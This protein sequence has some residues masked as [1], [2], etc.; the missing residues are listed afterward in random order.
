MIRRQDL[1]GRAEG[2]RNDGAAHDAFDL[3]SVL[4]HGRDLLTPRLPCFRGRQGRPGGFEDTE[5][6][7]H[8]GFDQSDRRLRWIDERVIVD[9][10]GRVDNSQGHLVGFQDLDGAGNI[11]VSL[12]AAG[13]RRL[14]LGIFGHGFIEQYLCRR[15]I[16]RGGEQQIGDR[17]RNEDGHA[18]H[19][20]ADTADHHCHQA[21]EVNEA[22]LLLRFGGSAMESEIFLVHGDHLVGEAQ[23]NNGSGLRPRGP[24]AKV[25][26][27]KLRSSALRAREPGS[28]SSHRRDRQYRRAP[29]RRRHSPR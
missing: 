20:G 14:V 12:L 27:F 18:E 10:T 5:D 22:I 28:G 1:I 13:R 24:Q 6:Q 9:E 3:E 11:H 8:T 19:D 15:R 7:L 23:L 21:I 4:Q 25:C 2:Y 17:Q 29:A 26:W 16:G